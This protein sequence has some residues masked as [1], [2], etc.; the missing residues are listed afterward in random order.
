MVER[1]VD[2]LQ[3]GAVALF[4]AH[5]QKRAFPAADEM[6][7]LADEISQEVHRGLSNEQSVYLTP[8]ER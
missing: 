1:Q 5:A 4:D 2:E 7:V 6:A 3:E 8:L